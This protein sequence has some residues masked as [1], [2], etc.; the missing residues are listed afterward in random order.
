MFRKL[1]LAGFAAAGLTMAAAPDADAAG[2]IS[3]NN[4]Y[5]ALNIIGINNASLQWEKSHRQGQSQTRSRAVR[6]GGWRLFRR[7]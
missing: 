7:R 4:P 1:L 6:S 5:A 3:R 2:P